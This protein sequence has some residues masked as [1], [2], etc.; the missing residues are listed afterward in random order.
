MDEHF[1]TALI[2][3]AINILLSIIVLPLLNKSKL[4]YT[5]QIKKHYDEKYTS[6]HLI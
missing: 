4:P 5:T 2:A 1:L 3:G 6:Y